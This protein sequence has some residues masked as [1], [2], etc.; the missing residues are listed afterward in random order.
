MKAARPVDRIEHPGQPA[1]S[2]LVLGLL[3]QDRVLRSAFGQNGAHCGLGG[4]VGNGHR[5]EGPDIARIGLVR[6]LEGG[7]AEMAQASRVARPPRPH[8]RWTAPPVSRARR[9]ETRLPSHGL[10]SCRL[11]VS[12]GAPPRSGGAIRGCMT[13]IAGQAVVRR[14]C[15]KAR[16]Q[17]RTGGGAGFPGSRSRSGPA[18]ALP[19]PTGCHREARSTVSPC[20]LGCFGAVHTL[21]ES[22]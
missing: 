9:R 21:E 7:R 13:L 20:T 22:S 17:A 15:P 16:A 5:I 4:A 11:I 19:C 10:S 3:A 8:A 2:G 12:L 6:R 1:R 14:R 18:P